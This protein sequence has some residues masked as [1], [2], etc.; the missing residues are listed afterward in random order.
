VYQQH[1]LQGH[2][3]PDLDNLILP[4][5]RRPWECIPCREPTYDEINNSEWYK[6]TVYKYLGDLS[7]GKFILDP[8]M[9]YVDT[10]GTDKMQRNSLGP[11]MFTSTILH[12]EVRERASSWKMIGL[13][14]SLT[15]TSAA[16]RS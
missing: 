9:F 10:T 2:E 5:K 6:R 4:D 1:L 13:M 3:F 15:A 7:S 16:K 12:R 11:V 14:P 8:L